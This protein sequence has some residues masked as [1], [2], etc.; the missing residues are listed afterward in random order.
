DELAPSVS[1]DQAR[2]VIAR[3][4]LKHPAMKANLERARKDL[5]PNADGFEISLKDSSAAGNLVGENLYGNSGVA[6]S[7]PFGTGA[8]A[9]GILPNFLPGIVDLRYYPLRFS[10]LL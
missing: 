3:Q 2:G 8:V 5:N 9:P 10:N 7:T 6:Y 4:L 1:L